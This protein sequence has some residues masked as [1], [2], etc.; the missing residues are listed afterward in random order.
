MSKAFVAYYAYPQSLIPWY[1]VSE[2]IIFI[3]IKPQLDTSEFL[4][5]CESMNACATILYSDLLCATLGLLAAPG[6]VRGMRNNVIEWDPPFT[7]DITD[8]PDITSYTVYEWR[9]NQQTTLADD[10]PGT[11]TSFNFADYNRTCERDSYYLVSAF[12]M[13]GEGS[14]SEEVSGDTVCSGSTHSPG[15]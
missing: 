11:A 10:I 14:R 8:A 2:L 13:V 3:P 9:S 12:N 1:R 5:Y 15:M 4:M 7:L 6:N